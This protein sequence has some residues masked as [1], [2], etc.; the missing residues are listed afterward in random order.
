LNTT[1]PTDTRPRKACPYCGESIL[2]MAQKCPHCREYLDPGLRAQQRQAPD[3]IDRML[4]PVGRPASAIAAGYLGLLS[5]LPFVGIFAIITSL[6]AL[7][8][9]KR[10]PELSGSGRAIFGLVMGS[11][12]TFLYAIPVLVAVFG[13]R[14]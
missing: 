1:N 6:V 12:M 5:L 11:I 9:L 13:A 2:A 8:T 14:P 4:M 10:K 3:G 7:R